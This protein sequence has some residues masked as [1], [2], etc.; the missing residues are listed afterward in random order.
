MKRSIFLIMLT[1]LLAACSSPK[2]N[3]VHTDSPI[4]NITAELD[5]L[6]DVGASQNGAYVKNKTESMVSLRYL[7]TWYD[8]QGVTQL[9]DY[10]TPEAWHAL[11]LTPKQRYDIPLQRPTAQSVN[12]RLY[13]TEQRTH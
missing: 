1:A 11:S 9:A 7:L 10:Q 5:P 12:Y 6:V 8:K 4:V 3:L 2:P 13:L